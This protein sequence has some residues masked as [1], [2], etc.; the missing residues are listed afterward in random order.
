MRT[1]QALAQLLP[2]GDAKCD[3]ARLLAEL[4]A[5]AKACVLEAQRRGPAIPGADEIARA[6]VWLGH[7]VFLCGHHRSGTTLLHGLLDG[8]PELLVLPSEGT[9]FTSFRYVTG[10]RPSVR[11]LE[12]FIAEWIAR[13]VDPNFEPHFRLGR[14]DETSQPYV[15]LARGFFGWHAALRVD[16]PKSFAPLLALVAAFKC[17][18]HAPEP[19]HWVEKTPLNER[20]V[21][22]LEAFASAH[23]IQA[24]RHPATTLASLRELYRG[25]VGGD[26]DAA[27]H[28]RA[29]AN[30]LRLAHAN[31][32][33]LE[34][35]YLV[36][37]YEDLTN[38]TA[39]EMARVRAFLDLAP[40]ASLNLPTAG[41]SP[42]RSNSSFDRGDA[43]VVNR[44]RTVD[45]PPHA[46]TAAISVFAG[47]A[48]RIFGY[49]I[50]RASAAKSLAVRLR[51]MPRRAF[52]WLRSGRLHSFIGRHPRP[53]QRFAGNSPNDP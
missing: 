32:R 23:Y 34:A 53:A 48:A 37:R 25:N 4:S 51:D 19:R 2:A 29:I 13:F 24:V 26:F 11:L 33:R 27:G 44:A 9:Y 38:A 28:A 50:A 14:S 6:R 47:N 52:K 17:A 46:D 15:D 7:P 8:H 22:R 20:H 39:S 18:V 1:E 31:Q 3:R 42:L 41:G 12:G 5:Y 35:R 43:G 16:A 21:S 45:L 36:V 49:D 10:E 30:S 40:S